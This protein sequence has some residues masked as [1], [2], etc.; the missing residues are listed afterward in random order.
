MHRRW[1]VN[2]R[3][4]ARLVQFGQYPIPLGYADHIEMPH[5]V[6]AGA[7]PGQLNLWPVAD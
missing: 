6:V 1:I 3:A 7:N 5:M 4:D 2:T